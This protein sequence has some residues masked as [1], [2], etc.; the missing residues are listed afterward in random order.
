MSLKQFEKDTPNM[1]GN[2]Y[3]LNFNSDWIK[4]FFLLIQ[5]NANS[6][7]GDVWHNAFVTPYVNLFL[8]S[9]NNNKTL[10]L[11]LHLIVNFVD[12]LSFTNLI[13]IKLIFTQQ[14]SIFP[15]KLILINH[16]GKIRFSNTI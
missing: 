5:Y 7:Q 16:V 3:Q 14:F 9:R 2:Q 8:Q 12:Q 10:K 13:F 4:I 11:K 1:I 15:F 6:S